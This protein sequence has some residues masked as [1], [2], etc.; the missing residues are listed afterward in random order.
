MSWK[1]TTL[2][3]REAFALFERGMRAVAQRDH[4]TAEQLGIKLTQA[5]FDL[6]W[7]VRARAASLRQDKKEAIKLMRKCVDSAPSIGRLWEALGIFFSNANRFDEALKAFVRALKCPD[8]DAPSILLSRAETHFRANQPAEALASA[9]QILTLPGVEPDIRARARMAEIRALIDLKQWTET[10]QAASEGLKEWEEFLKTKPQGESAKD[11]EDLLFG[12][13]PDQPDSQF[14]A[15][16]G[17]AALHGFSDRETAFAHFREAISLQNDNPFALNLRRELRGD[18]SPHSKMWLVM[19]GSANIAEFAESVRSQAGLHG[20]IGV[21]IWQ[22]IADNAEEA[23]EFVRELESYGESTERL[24]ESV[25]EVS[26]FPF[27]HK[28][29]FIRLEEITQV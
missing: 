15:A 16:L 6:G 18:S 17:L 27:I 24:Y 26:A 19:Q 9:R 5:G 4:Q 13:F 28:G 3:E 25:K 8:A 10:R 29:V 22:V 21:S 12:R 7:E 1:G 2:T 11:L 14:H 20:G 23:L